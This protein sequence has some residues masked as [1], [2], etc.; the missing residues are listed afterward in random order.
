MRKLALVLLLAAM[1]AWAEWSEVSETDKFFVYVDKSTLRKRGNYIKLWVMFDFKKPQK[2]QGGGREF[3]SSLLQKEF[4]CGEEQGRT[5]ASTFYAEGD[6]RGDVV[7]T[8][9]TPHESWEPVIPGTIG[10]SVFE[11]AC[12]SR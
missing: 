9:N 6:G 5:L 2:P 10:M 3:R 8:S 4:N 1:P 11:S 7:W 12:E